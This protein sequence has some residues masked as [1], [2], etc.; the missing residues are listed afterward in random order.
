MKRTG[1]IFN[2]QRFAIHDGPGIR[3][4]VFFKG[5][6]LRCF[7]CHNP[8]SWNAQTEL[9]VLRH[10]CICCGSCVAVCPNGCHSVGLDSGMLFHRES[11]TACGLCESICPTN[12][13]TLCGRK[14]TVDDV[15]VEVLKDAP[16]YAQSG[17]GVTFS[18]GECMLQ[19]DFL[20]AC[21]I[22]CKKWGIHT[23]IDTA[24]NVPYEDFVEILPYADL[25]LYDIKCIDSDLHS[26]GTGSGNEQILENIRRLSATDASIVIRVP[27][28]GGFNAT[29]TQMQNIA[30]FRDSLPRRHN[31]ELMPYHA[32]G[33]G[34]KDAFGIAR[35]ADNADVPQE[36]IQRFRYL[37]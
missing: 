37:F 8:E 20:K 25:F 2:L 6:N 12:A 15:M 11:C 31:V 23:A 33:E 29:E 3:M 18:G 7:W 13:L 32:F 14:M 34:K 22:A 30:A 35:S 16:F 5:C 9:R 1:I 26:R 17:G 36:L 24:G 28:I 10:L 19:T 21:L 27:V 4:T